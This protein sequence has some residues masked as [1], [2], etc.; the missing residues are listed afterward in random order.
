MQF[1]LNQAVSFEESLTCEFKEVKGHPVQAIGKIVDEYVVA[2]L[3]AA[4]GSLYWGIRDDDRVVTGVS[5][6]GKVQDELR[7]VIGQKTA[8][9]APPIPVELLEVPF[10]PVR[11]SAGDLVPDLCVIELRVAKPVEA[12]LFLTGGG[13]AYRRT[14][15]GTKKLSGAE[16][17]V[18]LAKPLQAKV[19]QGGPSALLSELPTVHRRAEVVQPLIRGRRVLWVDDHPSNNFYERVALAEIG[20]NADVAVSTDEGLHFAAYSPPDVIVSDME[21]AGERDA[22]LELL[23][24]ARQ[25]GIRAP[26]IF[27]VGKV[28]QSLGTPAGAF[29]IT[30]R[31]DDLLHLILDVLERKAS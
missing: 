5:A 14:I 20:L 26:V 24:V 17:L 21:R 28:L 11:R 9:V 13:E 23:R 7:Q 8:S 22:G 2:F 19:P 31:P 3:N 6:S 18:A 4:G 25:R 27:Y 30:D 12:S 10:H 29:A 16:L 15:G 1:V